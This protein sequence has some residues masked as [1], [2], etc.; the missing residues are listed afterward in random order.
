VQWT[1]PGQGTQFNLNY[2]QGARAE[3]TTNN[4]RLYM[5]AAEQA[6]KPMD[7]EQTLKSMEEEKA[8]LLRENAGLRRA[9]HDLSAVAQKTAAHEAKVLELLEKARQGALQAQTVSN[10]AAMTAALAQAWAED[11][12]LLQ[13]V[14]ACSFLFAFAIWWFFR[15][16]LV[17][18]R[19]GSMGYFCCRS[20]WRAEPRAESG[21]YGAVHGSNQPEQQD[22]HPSRGMSPALKPQQ[23]EVSDIQVV[24][25]QLSGDIYVSAELRGG[26]RLCTE[27]VEVMEDDPSVMFDRALIVDTRRMGGSFVLRVVEQLPTSEESI[28][29]LRI[30]AQEFLDLAANRQNE[31]N[32]PLAVEDGYAQASE[33]PQIV[34]RVRQTSSSHSCQRRSGAQHAEAH[35]KLEGVVD[36]L[37]V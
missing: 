37:K 15:D 3:L 9:L 36:D 16:H 30:S 19:S 13:F 20:M 18:L 34:M 5:T 14:C 8:T 11:H 22:I 26:G 27:V 24:G 23:F 2:P 31:V 6:T 25:V 17:K 32:F 12:A 4:Q 29:H 1:V 10:P 35:I 28:A 21:S 33:K 7:E